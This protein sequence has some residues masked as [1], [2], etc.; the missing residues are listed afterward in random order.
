MD[1]STVLT[2]LLIESARAAYQRRYQKI[3]NPSKK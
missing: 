3:V 1:A 2:K